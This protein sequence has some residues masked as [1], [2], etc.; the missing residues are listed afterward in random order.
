MVGGGSM[1]TVHDHQAYGYLSAYDMNGETPT[2]SAVSQPAHGT[3]TLN[4]SSFTYTPDTHFVGQDSFTFDASDSSGTSDPGTETIDVTNQ[5][6]MVSGGS[7]TTV[8]DHS[9]SGYLYAYDEDSD[10]GL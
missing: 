4:G 3:L 5:A 1:S 6:P 8:H 10:P 7:I 9:E 2:I